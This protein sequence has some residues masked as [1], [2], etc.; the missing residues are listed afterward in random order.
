MTEAP[1]W[2]KFLERSPAGAETAAIAKEK[3]SAR[4]FLELYHKG[5]Q[6]IRTAWKEGDID[7]Q[8]IPIVFPDIYDL[9]RYAMVADKT[10]LIYRQRTA[11]EANQEF[12]QPSN[13]D[14]S[15]NFPIAVSAEMK[16]KP[17]IFD[18][19]TNSGPTIV[20]AEQHQLDGFLNTVHL[21]AT[22]VNRPN[23]LKIFRDESNIS[24]LADQVCRRSIP[25]KPKNIVIAFLSPET[26]PDTLINL[27]W[28]SRM[29]SPSVHLILA[30]NPAHHTAA[31]TRLQQVNPKL[32]V[33]PAI[34]TT[35]T[36]SEAPYFMKTDA[37]NPQGQ[38]YF[39][40][41]TIRTTYT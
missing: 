18:L 40:L 26:S 6:R 30:I 19:T 11:A 24:F 21:S 25:V 29:Q 17:L 8:Y 7:D 41:R 23:R 3:D 1:A 27:G 13:P 14:N 33:L 10:P 39:P 38:K 37:T 28:I 2:L 16:P 12:T 35:L 34:P 32:D 20:I 22:F 9:L 15:R 31:I 4:L 5:L 36:F